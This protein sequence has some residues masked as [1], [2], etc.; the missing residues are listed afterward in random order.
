MQE[1]AEKKT[2]KVKAFQ[3]EM[4]AQNKERFH[5]IKEIMKKDE[6]HRKAVENSRAQLLLAMQNKH[7]GSFRATALTCNK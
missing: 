4:Q 6:D 1:K 2:E 5:K 3:S 7:R